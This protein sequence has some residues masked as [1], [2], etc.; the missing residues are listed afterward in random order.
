MRQSPLARSFVRQVYAP[1]AKLA[2]LGHG[3]VATAAA[4]YSTSLS[5]R[6]PSC[7]IQLNSV[8][9]PCV[10]ILRLMLLGF[11]NHNPQY[12]MYIGQYVQSPLIIDQGL[13]HLGRGSQRPGFRGCVF[14]LV[15]QSRKQISWFASHRLPDCST[16]Y[17]DLLVSTL[18]KRNNG[19]CIWKFVANIAAHSI[20]KRVQEIRLLCVFFDIL[21]HCGVGNFGTAKFHALF[22]FFGQRWCCHFHFPSLPVVEISDQEDASCFWKPLRECPFLFRLVPGM[23]EELA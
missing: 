3:Y 20:K 11:P 7:Q 21:M 15:R 17:G 10:I 23:F 9:N 14:S 5:T 6:Y 13:D 18:T 8:Q 12:I 19:W 2:W 4:L 22:H 16:R 1:T